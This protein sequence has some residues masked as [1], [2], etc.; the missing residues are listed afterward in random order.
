LSWWRI[1]RL[2]LLGVVAAMLLIKPTRDFLLSMVSRI[3][4]FVNEVIEELKKVSW[5]SR[6]EVKNS[7]RLVIFSMIMLAIFVGLIDQL[8]YAIIRLLL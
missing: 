3:R 8:L 4:G 7:T 2:I 1:L 6:T 5:P